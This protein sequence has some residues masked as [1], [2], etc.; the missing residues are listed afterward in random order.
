MCAS[1]STPWSAL[2]SFPETGKSCGPSTA[3]GFRKRRFRQSQ[4]NK[5]TKDEC[6]GR[7]K[8]PDGGGGSGSPGPENCKERA[9]WREARV[10][11]RGRSGAGFP[12]VYPGGEFARK[13][14]CAT[15]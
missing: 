2:S 6:P 7:A 12:D 11:G 10:V 9:V 4:Q 8:Q 5:R 1:C 13:V 14:L 15:A 3:A